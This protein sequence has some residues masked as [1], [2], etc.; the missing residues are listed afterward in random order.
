MRLLREYTSVAHL[1]HFCDRC[2]RYIQPGDEYEGF[3]Y[4]HDKHGIF[5]SKQ[6][7]NPACDWPDPEEEM[8]LFEGKSRTLEKTVKE[9]MNLRL[10]A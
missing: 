2:C 4:A 10:V 6:H 5:V 7:I 3:V 8:S 9:E 1:S